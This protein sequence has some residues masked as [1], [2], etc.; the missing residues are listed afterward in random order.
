MSNKNILAA[1]KK[2]G[3][4]PVCDN[5]YNSDGRCA[6]IGGHWHFS[7]MMLYTNNN[8]NDKGYMTNKYKV[9]VD[10][11]LG[12]FFYAGTA[13]THQSARDLARDWRWREGQVT[14]RVHGEAA[15]V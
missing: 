9:P 15:R 14:A 12:A 3:M 5:A 13:N 1:C 4:K 8:K 2:A 6:A 11:V 7:R 10:Q